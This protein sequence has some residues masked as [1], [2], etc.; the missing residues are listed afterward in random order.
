MIDFI[1]R[2]ILP[3]RCGLCEESE[4]L[5]FLYNQIERASVT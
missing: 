2:Y 3:E 5:S 1:D 4:R